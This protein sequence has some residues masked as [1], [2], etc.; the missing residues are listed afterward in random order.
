MVDSE[1]FYM[2]GVKYDRRHPTSFRWVRT[3]E[4]FG[5]Q[6]PL[7]IQWIDQKFF[8]RA[9]LQMKTGT[10]MAGDGVVPKII[11]DSSVDPPYRRIRFTLFKDEKSIATR[12]MVTLVIPLPD[13]KRCKLICDTAG[14][15][16]GESKPWDFKGTTIGAR[17]VWQCRKTIIHGFWSNSLR[18]IVLQTW[19]DHGK[20]FVA[21]TLENDRRVATEQHDDIASLLHVDKQTNA[22]TVRLLIPPFLYERVIPFPH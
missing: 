3:I 18:E 14:E 2:F 10:F 21:L 11:P 1:L 4:L 13:E 22:C 17:P 16:C 12:D 15:P 20:R 19:R 8:L 7:I 5:K 6:E 9:A